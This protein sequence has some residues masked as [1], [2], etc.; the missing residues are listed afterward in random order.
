MSH[1]NI[2]LLIFLQ[3]LCPTINACAS[4]IKLWGGCQLHLLTMRECE[5]IVGPLPKCLPTSIP[6]LPILLRA[7]LY[8]L[9]YMQLFPPIIHLFYLMRFSILYIFI[10]NIQPGSPIY[11]WYPNPP[12]Y[13]TKSFV[14]NFACIILCNKYL[15]SLNHLTRRPSQ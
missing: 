10:S 12:Q 3:N 15:I 8:F 4:A 7:I 14:D 5:V 11:L 9:Q 13:M 2:N 1:Q 6:I